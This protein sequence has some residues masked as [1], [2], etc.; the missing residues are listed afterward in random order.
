MAEKQV[1][2]ETAASESDETNRTESENEW[3]AVAKLCCKLL[4]LFLGRS[5][6]FGSML[7][8]EIRLTSR[9]KCG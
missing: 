8:L 4:D 7:T 3:V 2:F 9:G 6:G 1:L 5:E